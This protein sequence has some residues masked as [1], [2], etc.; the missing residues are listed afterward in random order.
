MYSITD[1]CSECDI[2]EAVQIIVY[3]ST[4]S[5]KKKAEGKRGGWG[6]Q[7]FSMSKGGK[8]KKAKET[9]LLGLS[10]INFSQVASRYIISPATFLRL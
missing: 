2:V 4:T 6:R 10:D 7:F 1:A 8:T 9:D 3:S 5:N